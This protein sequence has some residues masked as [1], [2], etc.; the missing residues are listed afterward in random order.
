MESRYDERLMLP[1]LAAAACMSAHH[2][3]RSFR[4]AFGETPHHYL[5]Q[6][7]LEAARRQLLTTDESVTEVAL[8]VGFETPGSFCTLFR[9]KFGTPPARFRELHGN[10]AT[11]KK[12][13]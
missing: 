2:F 11:L 13:R 1:D 4:R 12:R 6:R 3:L 10:R 9:R 8:A 7:R 5:T